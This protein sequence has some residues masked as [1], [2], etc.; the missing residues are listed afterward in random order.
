MSGAVCNETTSDLWSL[1]SEQD[2]GQFFGN[3]TEQAHPHVFTLEEQTSTKTQKATWYWCCNHT[4]THV[5]ICRRDLTKMSQW[6]ERKNS[7]DTEDLTC[8]ATL[9][10]IWDSSQ[11]LTG[12]WDGSIFSAL[13]S[14]THTIRSRR[15]NS[16]CSMR[17]RRRMRRRP[18]ESD[19]SASVDK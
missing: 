19:S 13:I 17:R 8:P 9:D 10:F 11:W 2:T 7:S 12:G 18:S 3:R 15:L 5:I 16:E 1:E 14:I 6:S 4:K